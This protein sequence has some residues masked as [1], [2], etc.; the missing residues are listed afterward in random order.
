MPCGTVLPGSSTLEFGVADQEV[1][2]TTQSVTFTA[3][4]DKK[5]ARNECGIV[6]AVAYYNPTYEVQIEVLGIYDNLAGTAL[7]LNG[8]YLTVTGLLFV[9]EVTVTKANEEFVKTSIKAT[10]YSGI[11]TS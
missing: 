5:E 2:L 1:S 3:R 11:T 10:G 8:S 7:S 6:V 9:D 4:A